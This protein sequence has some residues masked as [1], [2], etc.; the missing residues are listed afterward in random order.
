MSTSPIEYTVQLTN[1]QY[2]DEIKSDLEAV[3]GIISVDVKPFKRLPRDLLNVSSTQEAF[4]ALW[5]TKLKHNSLYWEAITPIQI[6][7]R[8]KGK[9][10]STVIVRDYQFF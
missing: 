5:G 8:Y 2:A 10:S 6:P 7:E 4:E 9:V 1:P 3:V